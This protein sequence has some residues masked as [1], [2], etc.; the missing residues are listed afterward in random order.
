MK[1]ENPKAFWKNFTCL[2]SLSLA[3]P[4]KEESFRKQRNKLC[5]LENCWVKESCMFQTVLT[6]IFSL[7]CEMWGLVLTVLPVFQAVKIS[8]F[9]RLLLLSHDK[10]T[11]YCTTA[12]HARAH[13]LPP[14][15]Q[16]LL[17]GILLPSSM[18]TAWE[19]ESCLFTASKV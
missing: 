9:Q 5:H 3:S 15:A 2:R 10:T 17:L 12:F 1:R 6:S 8:D 16:Q 13:L 14:P 11:T 4:S 18:Y 7:E 19:T